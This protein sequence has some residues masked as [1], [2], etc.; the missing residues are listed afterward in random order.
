MTTDDLD[1]VR[2]LTSHPNLLEFCAFMI[3]ERGDNSF[4]CFNLSNLLRLPHLVQHSFAIDY[5]GGIEN[6]ILVAHGGTNLDREYGFNISNTTLEDIYPKDENRDPLL[7]GYRRSFVEKKNFYCRR[8]SQ[9][10]KDE[11][12]PNRIAECLMFACSQNQHDIDYGWGVVLFGPET[13]PTKGVFV[14]W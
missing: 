12:S 10:A 14:N 11:W 13:T 6:G 1:Y 9:F 5:R 7:T 8:I 2:T 3:E 4:P